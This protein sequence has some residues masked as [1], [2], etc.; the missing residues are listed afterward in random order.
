MVDGAGHHRAGAKPLG[1]FV[2][3]PFTEFIADVRLENILRV[4][5]HDADMLFL[6]QHLDQHAAPD[7][8]GIAQRYPGGV[9]QGGQLLG[10]LN[11]PGFG[12]KRAERLQPGNDRAEQQQCQ[13]EKSPPEQVDSPARARF[14][15]RGRGFKRGRA[16][17]L[18]GKR[19][20]SSGFGMNG[21]SGTARRQGKL[22]I[23]P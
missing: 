19:L 3:N 23:I 1:E 12:F 6:G 20:A 14:K 22:A 8:I 2:R 9:D 10:I 18:H 15:R 16:G 13:K 17:S 21:E 4:A 7:R 11:R 5:R